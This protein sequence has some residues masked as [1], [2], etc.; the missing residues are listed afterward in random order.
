MRSALG[1]A[2]VAAMAAAAVYLAMR[3]TVADGKQYG[4]RMQVELAAKG[5]TSVVCDDEIPIVHDGAVFRCEVVANNGE[6]GQVEIS[7][8]RV[9]GAATKIVSQTPPRRP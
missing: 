8:D 7:L 1:V 3:P 5:I 4:A 9:G 6:S 2:F